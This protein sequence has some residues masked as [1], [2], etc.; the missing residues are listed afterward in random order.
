MSLAVIVGGSKGIGLGIAK[1]I[2]KDTNLQVV[3]LSRNKVQLPSQQ[4]AHMEMDVLN[5]ATIESCARKLREMGQIKYFVYS[6][7]FLNPE[8]SLGQIDPQTVLRHFE[9]NIIGAMQ[10]AKHFAPLIANPAKTKDRVVWAN[11]SAKTGSI[12]D[13]KLGG[14]HSYRCSKAALNQL[15][16]IMSIELGRK[17]IQVLAL[18]PGTVDTDLSR[19]YI[20]NVKHEIHT[21]DHAGHLMYQLISN[22]TEN[23]VFLDYSGKHLPW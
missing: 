8:K 1:S 11:M 7:G 13:N 16:K 22:T 21:A 12:E 23:G 6:A 10:C 20:G 9:T 3:A 19:N 2:L 4:F 14:W 5:P 17:G 15:T 18:H